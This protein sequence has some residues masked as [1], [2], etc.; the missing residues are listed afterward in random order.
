MFVSLY[1]LTAL[2]CDDCD[3]LTLTRGNGSLQ[4]PVL[5][6]ALFLRGLTTPDDLTNLT[7]ELCRSNGELRT[8]SRPFNLLRDRTGASK[9]DASWTQV[10]EAFIASN[11]RAFGDVSSSKSMASDRCVSPAASTIWRSSTRSP[12]LS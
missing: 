10:L 5:G 4:L 11:V 3:A 8:A 1:S 9:G 12:P 7:G 6:F 2:D